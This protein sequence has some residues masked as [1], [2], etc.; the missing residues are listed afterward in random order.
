MERLLREMSRQ[1]LLA[2]FY[3]AGGTGL[4]LRLGHRRSEDLDLFREEPFDPDQLLEGAAPAGE[5][6]VV[7]KGERTLHLEIQGIRVSF[8]GFAYPALFPG[9][10]FCGIPVA[11][12]RDI[13]C[14][15][16]SAISGR[17][18]RR[19]FVDVY[20]AAQTYGLRD[21]LELFHR[22]FAR[23]QYNSVHV[24]KSLVY[25]ADAEKDPMPDLLVPLSW[26]AVKQFF[27]R[28]AVRL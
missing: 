6:R 16:I 23:V 25:F 4:A 27:L 24:R 10:P 18:A 17:G 14:M 19:D 28:E 13:A 15:K 7:A 20:V 22:K 21:L 3:L 12:A 8:L 9:E 2:G 5:V 11:D 26:E 1:S